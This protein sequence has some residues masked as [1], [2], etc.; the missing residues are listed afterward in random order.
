MEVVKSLFGVEVAAGAADPVE[1]EVDG[2]DL[3]EDDSEATD[4]TSAKAG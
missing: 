1:V 4:E 2:D 3:D